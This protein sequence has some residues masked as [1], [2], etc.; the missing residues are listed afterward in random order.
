MDVDDRLWKFAQESLR[1]NAH[2]SCKTH[3]T[4]LASLQ[5]PGELSIVIFASS[6]R[7]L[8]R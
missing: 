3:Q 6:K 7:D 5:L 8:S 1:Q 2:E 4:D